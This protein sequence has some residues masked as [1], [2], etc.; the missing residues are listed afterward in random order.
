MQWHIY[1]KFNIF[2]V[3]NGFHL[4]KIQ[5]CILTSIDGHILWYLDEYECY[6]NTVSICLYFSTQTEVKE[7]FTATTGV[8][9]FVHTHVRLGKTETDNTDLTYLDSNVIPIWI[10]ESR[11]D[12]VDRQPFPEC[13]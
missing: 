1:L 2:F 8:R 4:S 11:L 7:L 12:I 9:I 6:H 10:P 5:S 13:L 3:D